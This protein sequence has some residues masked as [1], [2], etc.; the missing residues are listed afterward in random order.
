MAV[1]TCSNGHYYDNSLFPEC[2]YCK[3]NGMQTQFSSNS[4]FAGAMFGAK[5]KQPNR[6]QVV[7]NQHISMVPENPTSLSKDSETIMGFKVGKYNI[8]PLAGWLVCT[9]GKDKGK[10]FPVNTE[11]TMIGRSSSGMYTVD[12]TEDRICLNSAVASIAYVRDSRSFMISPV[13]GSN[14][15]LF[16]NTV[17]IHFPITLNDNDRINIGKTT[18]VFVSF[19]NINFDWDEYKV[20]Y[21][22][23]L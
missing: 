19:C 3:K 5:S 10:D 11:K 20:K 8:I 18:L 13:P 7:E 2:P 16:L 14:L 4:E 23:K 6:L 22:P 9:S 21:P 15:P 1:V 17:D 12:L